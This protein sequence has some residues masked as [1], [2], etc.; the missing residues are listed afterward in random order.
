M[1]TYADHQHLI[2]K[3]KYLSSKVIP[4]LRLFD[5]HVGLFYTKNGTPVRIG[6]N[7]QADVWGIYK[8][9]NSK[10][11]VHIELEF[12]TGNAVQSKDQKN[13]EKF[14]KDHNGIYLLIRRDSQVHDLK[15]IL[16]TL[17]IILDFLS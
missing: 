12:K 14:I 11:L 15:K 17:E 5:R 10:I 4:N 8:C 13:W 2:Q 3:F 9:K 16:D 1:T 6:M 7:G